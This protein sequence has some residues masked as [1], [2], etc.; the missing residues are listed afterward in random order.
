MQILLVLLC[1]NTVSLHCPGNTLS[2]YTR[3]QRTLFQQTI[4]N[5]CALQTP[6]SGKAVHFIELPN[7]FRRGRIKIRCAWFILFCE[8]SSDGYTSQAYMLLH[9][10][11][12][13]FL[14]Q[15]SFQFEERG[16]MIC[17][18][19]LWKRSLNEGS[20]YIQYVML[21]HITVML[22]LDMII[23]YQALFNLSKYALL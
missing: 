8:C 19:D 21:R 16:D 4:F 5:R 13:I 9:W 17:N 14:I 15:P 22:I 12:R 20:F 18:P 11:Y 6:K 1:T 2:M 10:I 3:Q 23:I 7:S